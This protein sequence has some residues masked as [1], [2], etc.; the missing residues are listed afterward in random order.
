MK[1]STLLLAVLFVLGLSS[2]SFAQSKTR[3]QMIDEIA[4][5]RKELDTLEK[6]FLDV[7]ETDRI[8]FAQ[9]LSQPNTGL[10]RLLPRE[11]FDSEVYKKS[12]KTITMRG[13]GAY[14]SFVQLTHE[15]GFGSDISLDHDK[16]L[17]GFAGLDYGMIVQVLEQS[18]D[19][20]SGGNPSV[21]P[22]IDYL[23]PKTEAAI[24]R[25]QTRFGRGAT[26]DDITLRSSAPVEVGATY[27]LRSISYDR[28]DILVGLKVARK[29]SDGSLIIAWKLLN[30]FAAPKVDREKL[31]KS[32]VVSLLKRNTN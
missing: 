2:N 20:L 1:R 10:I 29:D 11:K 14:Y 31:E 23:P 19:D 13:A 18:L 8:A 5:K 30:R 15:Y 28:S 22:L 25:E 3:E 12:Q 32:Q 17:V 16:L 24:R 9:L 21:R 7:S 27:L 26:I 4:A 6:E